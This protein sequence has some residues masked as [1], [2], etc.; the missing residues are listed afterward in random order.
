MK[1]IS[2]MLTQYQRSRFLFDHSSISRIIF[3][4]HYP[5]ARRAG[6]HWSPYYDIVGMYCR[7]EIFLQ[8]KKK[9]KKAEQIIEWKASFYINLT[10]ESN[11]SNFFLHYLNCWCLYLPKL[12]QQTIV[13]YF[14]NSVK[15]C[16]NWSLFSGT[17][18]MATWAWDYE[19]K[20]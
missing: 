13:L 10:L 17:K 16:I 12:C 14:M 9:K 20:T 3:H 18:R 5:V 7:L 11:D 4:F 8:V 6:G 2:F 1:K 15:L 19:R